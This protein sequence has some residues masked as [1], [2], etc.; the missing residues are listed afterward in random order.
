MKLLQSVFEMYCS[1][2]E[3]LNELNSRP[4]LRKIFIYFLLKAIQLLIFD[5]LFKTV[6]KEYYIMFSCSKAFILHNYA[7]SPNSG[8]RF[9][10][11]KNKMITGKHGD[12]FEKLSSKYLKRLNFIK[13]IRNS[14]NY[15]ASVNKVPILC[16]LAYQDSCRPTCLVKLLTIKYV[17]EFHIHFQSHTSLFNIEV[18][19]FS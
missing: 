19:T 2:L 10:S 1:T 17:R 12:S 7:C 13:T 18:H 11:A 3:L 6:H 4:R 16:M 9:G 5:W 14:P 15:F 8:R